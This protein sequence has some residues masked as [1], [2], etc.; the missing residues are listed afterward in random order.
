MELLTCTLIGCCIEF[1]L[2]KQD[3]KPA[4]ILVTSK[5]V[6]KI[7]DLGLARTFNDPVQSLYTGDKVV[8]TIWYR[9]PELLL[10]SRHYT[11]A[12]DTWAVGAIFAELLIL[13]PI[14]KGDEVKMTN[15][16]QIPFQKDQFMKIVQVL[17]N[18]TIEMWPTI[19]HMPEYPKLAGL[20]SSTNSWQ[21]TL[22]KVSSQT[23]ER[24]YKLLQSLLIYDP[25][26]R[27][28]ADKASQSSYFQEEPYPCLKY[29]YL[30]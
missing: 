2:L 25:D 22:V 3:L 26:K 4:N 14:F 9:A 13:R 5:G 11:K 12:I 8:V 24:G 29:I 18:P 16:K 20:A 7:A 23:T 28:S 6:V 30:T 15:K 27:S 21:S 19:V 10:G 1:N 17:G